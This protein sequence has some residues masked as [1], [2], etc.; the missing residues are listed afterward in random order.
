MSTA[1]MSG[2]LMAVMPVNSTSL[3]GWHELPVLSVPVFD[4]GLELIGSGVSY[5]PHII[6]SAAATLSGWVIST[7]GGILTTSSCVPFQC[8]VSV[9]YCEVLTAQMSLGVMTATA[10]K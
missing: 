5:R 7:D 6:G 2:A 10:C 1:Q 4:H 9:A 8:S 3:F